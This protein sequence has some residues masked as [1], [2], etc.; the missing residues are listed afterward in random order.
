[1]ELQFPQFLEFLRENSVAD[2]TVRGLKQ[3][4]PSVVFF[5]VVKIFDSKAVSKFLEA[6]CYCRTF[7]HQFPSRRSFSMKKKT[8]MKWG[9]W[10]ER[11]GLACFDWIDFRLDLQKLRK[12]GGHWNLFETSKALNDSLRCA[13]QTCRGLESVAKTECQAHALHVAQKMAAQL[14]TLL[15]VDD[16]GPLDNLLGP[17]EA[18]CDCLDCLYDAEKTTVFSSGKMTEGYSRISFS[19]VIFW[20]DSMIFGLPRSLSPLKRTMLRGAVDQYL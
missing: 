15:K 18:T 11:D 12:Y 10:S 13:C 7:A 3:G 20:T 16:H 4:K 17:F 8:Y 2:S 5:G 6:G 1:M 9:A 19:M 14:Q